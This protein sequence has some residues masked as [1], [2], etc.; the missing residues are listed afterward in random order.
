MFHWKLK[1]LIAECKKNKIPITYRIISA[2]TKISLSSLTSIAKDKTQR[3]DRRIVAKLLNFFSKKLDR[4]VE[5]GELLEWR[6]R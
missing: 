5:F 1:Q 2:E 6:N 4:K 3:V